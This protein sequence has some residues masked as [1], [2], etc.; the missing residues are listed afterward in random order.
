MRFRFFDYFAIGGGRALPFRVP[1]CEGHAHTD[2][3]DGRS[4]AADCAARAVEIGL[5][6]LV[7]TE[8]V[9]AGAPWVEAYF[10][11]VERLK[12]LHEGR[13]RIA[14]GV[15][16][17]V[18]PDGN[19]DA[20]AATL[21]RAEV[22]VGSYHGMPPRDGSPE[23]VMRVPSRREK[24]AAEARALES[25][26]RIPEVDVIG[27][28]FGAYFERYGPPPEE[29]M[30]SLLESAA[31]AGKAVEINAA[32]MDIAWFLG[33]AARRGRDFLFWPASDAHYAR[34]VGKI[35]DSI[36]GFM[37]AGG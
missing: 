1:L 9:H 10:A 17:R 7:F 18:L 3:T 6:A 29:Y 4:S 33:A 8:H 36:R 16:A 28:P 25:L 34:D 37:T 13:L 31:A 15:E 26:T 35:V 21:A 22:V 5:E 20:D 32:H 12:A 19:L 14:G 11:E 2:M 24:L 23:E 30:L 27:H